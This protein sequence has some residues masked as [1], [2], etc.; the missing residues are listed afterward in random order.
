MCSLHRSYDVTGDKKY[1][2]IAESIFEDIAAVYGT[3]PCGGGVWWD[4]VRYVLAKS[5][6]GLLVHKVP[7]LEPTSTRSQMNCS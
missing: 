3:T 7:S 6:Y 5:F 2:R 4:K 1:L